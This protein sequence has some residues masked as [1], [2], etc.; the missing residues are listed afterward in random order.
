MG[1]YTRSPVDVC[2]SRACFKRP[3]S[4]LSPPPAV[5]VMRTGAATWPPT[6]TTS[7]TRTQTCM[8]SFFTQLYSV[9]QQAHIIPQSTFSLRTSKYRQR[10]GVIQ[11]QRGRHRPTRQS[12]NGKKLIR[13]I[14]YQSTQHIDY[15]CFNSSFLCT[16]PDNII[17]E[18]RG[19]YLI[20]FRIN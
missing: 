1:H 16:I 4:T 10:K 7:Q 18:M 11:L 3:P 19:A 13:T 14:N 2:R 12:S 8:C 17:T 9:I 20:V 6:H 5:L 15:W